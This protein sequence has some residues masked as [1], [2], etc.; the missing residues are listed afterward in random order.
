MAKNAN[1]C[2]AGVTRIY[3]L[4]KD[5]IKAMALNPNFSTFYVIG[6]IKI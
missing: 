2:T 1:S 4:E 5:H 6:Y 3:R